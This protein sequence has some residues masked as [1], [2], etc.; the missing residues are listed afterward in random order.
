MHVAPVGNSKAKTIL[1]VGIYSE[2]PVKMHI[3]LAIGRGSCDPSSPA[4]TLRLASTIATIQCH[5]R[6]SGR[7]VN[8]IFSLILAHTNRTFQVQIHLI[9]ADRKGNQAPQPRLLPGGFPSGEE[10]PKYHHIS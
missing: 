3:Y 5:L 1:L 6:G 2:V 7:L 9:G 8:D 10:D 4:Q